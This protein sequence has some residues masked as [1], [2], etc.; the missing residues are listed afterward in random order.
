MNKCGMQQG[1]V[2]LLLLI[3]L[4]GLPGCGLI[5][6][7]AVKKSFHFDIKLVD[8]NNRPLPGIRIAYRLS[9]PGKGILGTGRR[10]HIPYSSRTSYFPAAEDRVLRQEQVSDKN[11][12]IKINYRTQ[13]IYFNTIVSKGYRLQDQP[14][15]AYK[16]PLMD[17]LV[18]EQA[19]NGSTYL[20]RLVRE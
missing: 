7:V 10:L 11:G 5:K 8:Q 19:G 20:L 3:L 1:W 9:E 18:Q 15:K 14:D 2:A 4:P 16:Y 17:F 12:I 13:T 6:S